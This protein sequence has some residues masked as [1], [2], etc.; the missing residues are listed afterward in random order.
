MRR[1]L[2]AAGACAVLGALGNPIE[3]PPGS[4]FPVHGTIA[5]PNGI[6][7]PLD[8][9]PPVSGPTPF[10][11]A[12]GGLGG[13]LY[14]DAEVEPWLAVNPRD[15]RHLV[16]VWQQDRWSNGSSRGLMTGVSF[17]G[18][19]SWTRVAV[20]FSQC[21]GGTFQ[22]ASDPWVDFS[23][24]GTA[25]QIA[26]VS[27]GASFASQST[28]AV[29]ASRSTDGGITWST[30]VALIQDTGS[31]FFNDKETITA[32][33][34]D[35]RFVYAVWDRLEGGSGGPTWFARS[36]D[37]GVS[38]EAAR[39]IYTPPSHQQT[40]GNLIRVLPDGTLVNLLTHL[41]SNDE[42]HFDG[43]FLE[44]LRSADRGATWSAPIRVASYQP[45]GA[46]D[47][48]THEDIRDGTPIGGM[49]V[50]PDG[51][52]YVVWQDAR[53]IGVRDAIALARSTDGGLT[54]S[55]PVRVSA[56]DDV[57]A[58]APQVHVAADGTIGVTYFTFPMAGGPGGLTLPTTYVISRSRDAVTWTDARIAGPFDL[59]RAPVAGGL[60]LGDYMGLASAAG[61]F[62]ALYTRTTGAE[63]DRTNV[64]LGRVATGAGNVAARMAEAKAALEDA[65]FQERVNAHLAR[66][67]ARRPIR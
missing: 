65:R 10:G 35:A 30:P 14:I 50:A 60:F 23:P 9:D 32:D 45:L 67:M 5:A 52:L 64:Y 28:N 22:R 19:L 1:A 57:V 33:P 31:T 8:R 7:R 20:P 3:R 36:T 58:F 38:W 15:A 18:G 53:F 46:E 59:K 56:G 39:P 55:T 44:V 54:W 62:L 37:G 17:D 49:A 42:G 2:I 27:T 40:I 43:A 66:S 16:A 26:L 6:A 21:A 11:L 4:I 51:A 61:D 24:D 48:V 34:L 63:S 25:H 29:M 13:V 47:P 12:C 41:S